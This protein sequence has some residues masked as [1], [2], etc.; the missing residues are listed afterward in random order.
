M[1]NICSVFSMELSGIIQILCVDVMC[2]LH[3]LETTLFFWISITRAHNNILL[4]SNTH[5]CPCQFC[6]VMIHVFPCRDDRLHSYACKQNL[7][8]PKYTDTFTHTHSTCVNFYCSSWKLR[9]GCLSCLSET[10]CYFLFLYVIRE[11]LVFPLISVVANTS[12]T[13]KELYMLPAHYKRHNLIIWLWQ[14]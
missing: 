8:P 2:V 14:T 10:H 13:V 7:T 5:P 12:L 3:R 11:L 6:P 9:E 1:A 4:L